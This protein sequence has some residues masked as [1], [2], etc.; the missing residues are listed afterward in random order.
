MTIC[1]EIVEAIK[2]RLDEILSLRRSFVSKD[3]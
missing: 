1:N 3:D 2:S